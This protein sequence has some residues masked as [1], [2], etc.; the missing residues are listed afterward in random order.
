MHRIIEKNDVPVVMNKMLV[1]GIF[2]IETVQYTLIIILAM[3]EEI[4][5]HFISKV[6]V[7]NVF[8]A[9]F[10]HIVIGEQ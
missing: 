7:I 5:Y 4:R 6:F 1:I 10:F 9:F 2:K 3:S 8:I